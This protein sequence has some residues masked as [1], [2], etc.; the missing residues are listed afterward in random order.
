MAPGP[1]I[2]ARISV[3]FSSLSCSLMSA[4]GALVY[5]LTSLMR[6]LR[7]DDGMFSLH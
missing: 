1:E 7:T 4:T 2:S 5:S 3:K 6:R